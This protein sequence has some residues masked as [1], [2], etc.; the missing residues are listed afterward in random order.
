MAQ[1]CPMCPYSALHA[2]ISSK[3]L[4]VTQCKNGASSGNNALL[5][6]YLKA[7]IYYDIL[8]LCDYPGKL[9]IKNQ[10]G[11]STICPNTDVFLRN[12]FAISSHFTLFYTLGLS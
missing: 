11:E 12:L 5:Y 4:Q 7:C 1:T 6:K 2:A 10:S 3:F 9:N 8:L